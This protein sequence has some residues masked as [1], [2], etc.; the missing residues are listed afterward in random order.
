MTHFMVCTY[1]LFQRPNHFNTIQRD[2]RFF[3]NKSL[4]SFGK[5]TLN[6]WGIFNRIKFPY[7]PQTTRFFASNVDTQR[8]VK[9]RLMLFA[10]VVC[11]IST[12]L[13]LVATATNIEICATLSS[14]QQSR[15]FRCFSYNNVQ[16]T[17]AR[18]AKRVVTQTKCHRSSRPRRTRVL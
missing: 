18:N 4:I 10:Q 6:D 5:L 16:S 7:V 13:T 1:Q 12:Q 15:I 9:P 8:A 2:S 17:M 11:T 14:F 3:N